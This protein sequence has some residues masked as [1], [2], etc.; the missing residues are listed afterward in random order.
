MKK[1]LLLTGLLVLVL[2]LLAFPVLTSADPGE[3]HVGPGHPYATI[4]AAVDAAIPYD[5]IIIHD[6]GT[7]PDYEENVDVGV[8]HLTIEEAEGEE[9]TVKAADSGDH[10]FEVTMDYVTIRGLD[11]YGAMSSAGIFLDNASDCTIGNN[12]CGWDDSYNNGLGI[13]LNASSDNTLTGN[14]CN[15]NYNGISLNDSSNNTLTDNTCNDH[16]YGIYLWRSSDNTL[17]GNICSDNNYGIYLWRSSDNTLM[18]NTCNHNNDYG[19]CLSRSSDNTLTDNSMSDNHRNFGVSGMDRPHYIQDIDITNTVDGKPIYYWVN[20]H[21]REIP[22]DAGYVVVV[23]CTNITVQD[24]TLANNSHGVLFAYTSDSLIENVDVWSNNYGIS[25][26]HSSN[27]TLTD[28]T[29]NDNNRGICLNDSSDNHIYLNNFIDNDIANVYS[30]ISTNTWNSPEQM[31]YTYNGMSYTNYLGNYWSDYTGNDTNPEDGLGDTSY[32]VAGDNDDSYPLMLPFIPGDA[33]GDG[34]VD[35][36]DWVNVRRILEGLD[37]PT[38]GADAD[39]D[40]DVDVF[41]WVK[42]RRILEGLE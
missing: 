13:C 42:V 11:I 29:C 14:T 31:T 7:D 36:F 34:D 19:I 25:L 4:Q 3:L 39:E 20:Q 32:L 1:R 38:C 17:M 27:N 22:N 10:V 33:D 24:L 15:Q 30:T 21:D 18:G 23:G 8:N 40:S 12:R 41:D 2:T 9:V 37:D 28:N 6:A 5:T 26:D 35:V 16:N